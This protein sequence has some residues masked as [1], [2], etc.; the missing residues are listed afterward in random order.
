MSEMGFSYLNRSQLKIE[1][2]ISKLMDALNK[3]FFISKSV[4]TLWSYG[5]IYF[6]TKQASY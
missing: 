4:K 2:E 5:L 1:L 6:Y 3:Y